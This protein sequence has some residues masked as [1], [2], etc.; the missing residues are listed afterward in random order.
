[1]QPQDGTEQWL[2][3]N[4]ADRPEMF[5]L[6][7][8]GAEIAC[9]G[10]NLQ[11][12]DL[13]GVILVHG[14]RAHVHWWDHIAP[15]L[16]DRY[17][18]AAFSF[19]GM[20][21]SDRRPTY[22]RS[23]YAREI[24]GLAAALDFDPAIVV[25]HSFGAIPSL[26]AARSAPD[27]ISRVIVID[28]AIPASDD[29]G[30]QIP[31]PPPRF[32][33]DEENAVSRFRLIPPGEWPHPSVLAHIAQH[34]VGRTAEGWT[35][36]FDPDAAASLNEENYRGAMFDIPVP[37]DMIRGE[38]SEIMTPP[39]VAALREMAPSLGREIIIPASHHHILIEQP[40]SLCAALNAL[41][42]NDRML[43]I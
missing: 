3:R 1:M 10:W 32:Y 24:L 18:V 20:G 40:A 43:Q 17:R 23:Q 28:S 14:F 36:K 19:S 30:R 33:P 29:E 5:R 2:Q 9:H 38:H 16:A 35:W 41:L 31:T 7:V 25:A 11:A 13:P 42:A 22:S 12:R 34:S 37:V 39:R 26:I 27:R 6:D 4:W 8:E 21:D 15:A